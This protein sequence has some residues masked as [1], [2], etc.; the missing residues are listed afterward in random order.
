MELVDIALGFVMLTIGAASTS[1]AAFYWTP[2]GL[3]LLSFGVFALLYGIQSLLTAQPVASL[4]GLPP[5]AL[6]YLGS[7][8]TYW[9]PVPG[10]IF[11]EQILGSGWWSAFRRLWQGWAVLATAFMAYD[12]ANG[13]GASLPA[14]QV[15]IVLLLVVILARVA[16]WG[17]PRT[18]ERLALTI[19]FT[20]VVG[21]GGKL[22]TEYLHP[23]PRIRDGTA[24]LRGAA[25][26]RHDGVRV[27]HR[28]RDPSVPSSTG[29]SASQRARHR[30]A[31]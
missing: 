6:G 12:F 24:I 8:L 11:F 31:L 10:L 2:G 15:P 26:A 19:G 14:T 28:Q 18:A 9:L 17:F 23:L 27:A 13:P 21:H 30:G 29:N 4:V 7:T 25:G 16:G 20:V 1:L 22:R 3:T 5:A